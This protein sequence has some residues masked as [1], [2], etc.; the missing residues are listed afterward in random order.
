MRE[1]RNAPTLE[2]VARAA[3]VS[4]ATVSRVLNAPDKV[5]EQT[6]RRVRQAVLQLGY[7]PHFGARAMAANRTRTIGAIIPT[8]ENAIFAR[9]IQAFQEALHAQGYTLLVA[10][11][12]YSPE[13]EQEQI[14]TL[15]ARGADGLLL[16]GHDRDAG[17]LDFLARH[18]VPALVAWSCDPGARLPSVGF[19]N[20]AAMHALAARALD[21]GHRRIGL[22]TA[23]LARNDRARGRAEGIWQ[24]IAEAGLPAA[25][26]RVEET[27]YGIETGAEAFGRI[28]SGPRP[29]SLV[30]CGNDV[31][32]VGALMRAREMGLAVP[33][34][35]SITG[36]DDIDLARIVLPALTTV[37][38]P[39][40]EMGT[41][42]AK[43]LIDM[44]E[45]RGAG[46]RVVLGTEIR[47]RDT[48][49]P[50]PA[51]A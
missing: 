14:E 37:H 20:R 7:V 46:E 26:L 22:I 12:S 31:L 30:F 19:D 1:T 28:V 44:V 27:A 18:R 41:R 47:L 38:V 34:E 2:D 35:V 15:V 43:V 42:A 8:M 11:S 39:H 13:L 33:G 36:F 23:P 16:I 40:R 51:G 5:A 49:A 48:L 50:P 6:R 3:G 17:V 25:A 32:A 10:S 21:M 29:P 9:G 4:S 45:G 24:A